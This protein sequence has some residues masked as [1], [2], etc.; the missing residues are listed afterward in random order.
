MNILL[1]MDEYFLAEWFGGIGETI[2]SA[3][4]ATSV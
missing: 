2:G 1:I 4:S 3:T